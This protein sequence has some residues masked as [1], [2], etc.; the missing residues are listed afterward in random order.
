ML[1]RRSS[2]WTSLLLFRR[3]LGG[4]L[5]LLRG[6]FGGRFGGNSKVQNMKNGRC[7]ATISSNYNKNYNSSDLN[8]LFVLFYM[9]LYACIGQQADL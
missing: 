3:W 6:R 2:F 1:G 5:L 4:L 7:I 9:C 8:V